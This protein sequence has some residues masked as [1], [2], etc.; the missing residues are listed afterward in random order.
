[1][2]GPPVMKALLPNKSGFHYARVGLAVV[3]VGMG[4]H[5]MA[6]TLNQAALARGRAHLSA[7]AW[8]L[9]AALFVVFV[10]AP[11]ISSEVLRVEVGY[12]GA[13]L[14]L[15]LL[16]GVIYRL[17]PAAKEP[18]ARAAGGPPAA[19]EPAVAPRTA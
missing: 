1:V 15:V 16:L 7:A 3:G 19:A 9:C 12:A 8:L 14:V 10:A 6:G 13:T 17:G 4:F 18:A 5:L 2:I 11:T